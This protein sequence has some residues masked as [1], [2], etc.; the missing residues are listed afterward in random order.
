MAETKKMMKKFM[1]GFEIEPKL[2][3][4]SKL[5][6][7]EKDI[8]PD[9]KPYV[10]SEKSRGKIS[11]KPELVFAIV[12]PIVVLL[13]IM[14]I[15]PL[16][17]ASAVN[18]TESNSQIP[19]GLQKIIEYNQSSTQ[20][21]ALRISFLIA[22]L[23][24]MLGILSPCVLPFVP[25][26]FS[27]TFKEKKNITLM[28]LVF[29]AG[30]SLVFI[31]MGIIAGFI[32]ERSMQFLQLPWLVTIAGILMI[33]MGILTISGRGIASVIKPDQH[34]RTRND[35]PGVFLA[36]ILFAVGWT[37][38]QGPILIGILGIGALLH[39]VFYS[40]V[41]LFF[42]SLGELTPLFILSVLY[43]KY[44]LHEKSFIKG[45][46]INFTFSGKSHSVHSTS[47]IS[48]LLFIALG[49]F[50]VIFKNTAPV[51]AYDIFGTRDY[52][53]SL[54]SK[55]L[56]LP[57]AN[58]IGAVGLAVVVAVIGF[59]VWKEISGKGET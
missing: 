42:Y 1:K 6:Q 23:A 19:I 8:K 56:A 26:Y 40:A 48:G 3:Q 32:G 49:L 15:L 51:N 31:T 18:D 35:I 22:F 12:I 17:I 29:F 30:F 39:N 11:K 37:A 21:F 50:L 43:D 10:N 36:G 4:K 20:D 44:R 38:C 41:L 5:N 34:F 53:Y 45:R 24:G 54:Q 55:L 52:F 27:Y 28:T 2:N 14:F 13:S 58:I 57:Y 46:E 25:A 7:I 16:R 9:I 59:F 33:L 47:L